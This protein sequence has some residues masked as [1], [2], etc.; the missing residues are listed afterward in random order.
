MLSQENSYIGGVLISGVKISPI[1]VYI[2]N[3]CRRDS[4]SSTSS[5]EVHGVAGLTPHTILW[6]VLHMYVVDLRNASLHVVLTALPS[7][8]RSTTTFLTLIPT[9]KF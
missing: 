6:Y 1:C 5:I 8:V 3:T 9:S 2:H 7:R 4:S